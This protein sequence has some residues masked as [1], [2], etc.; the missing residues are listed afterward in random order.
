MPT[1]W[2]SQEN[3]DVSKFLLGYPIFETFSCFLIRITKYWYCCRARKQTACSAS[4]GLRSFMIFTMNRWN[5]RSRRQGSSVEKWERAHARLSMILCGLWPRRR[6]ISPRNYL[7]F[8][9]TTALRLPF[10]N[11]RTIDAVWLETRLSRL[12]ICFSM[13]RISDIAYVISTWC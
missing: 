5:V 7:V 8:S 4:K 11:I 2:N 13:W 9:N 10:R 6:R 3:S 12:V 1:H